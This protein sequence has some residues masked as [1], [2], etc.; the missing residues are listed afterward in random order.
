M[1]KK[2]RA[3]NC[4]GWN[5]A[6]SDQLSGLL[7]MSRRTK[8]S[9]NCLCSI[10]MRILGLSLRIKSKK[11]AYQRSLL[12]FCHSRILSSTFRISSMSEYAWSGKN[13]CRLIRTCR[14]SPSISS[15]SCSVFGVSLRA[16]TLSSCSVSCTTNRYSA[17]IC[18]RGS[19]PSPTTKKQIT[20]RKKWR[21]ISMLM[22]LSSAFPP[23]VCRTPSIQRQIPRWM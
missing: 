6:T 16:S 23:W 7:R 10:R 13:D 12:R 14:Y 4:Y 1:T 2:M 3:E 5:S 8:P 9:R 19:W 20:Q 22:S 15:C 17:W 11:Q 21:S 18:L